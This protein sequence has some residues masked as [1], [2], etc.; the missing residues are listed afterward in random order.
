MTTPYMQSMFAAQVVVKQLTE[1]SGHN[2][3]VIARALREYT[4]AQQSTQTAVEIRCYVCGD[5]V[6]PDLLPY[7]WETYRGRERAHCSEQCRHKTRAKKPDKSGRDKGGKHNQTQ[8]H[9]AP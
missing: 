5:S 8:E 1:D 2:V 4:P 6:S 7:F 9:T 3:R